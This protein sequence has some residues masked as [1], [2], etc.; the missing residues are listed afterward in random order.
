VP[1]PK[2]EDLRKKAFVLYSGPKGPELVNR[3]IKKFGIKEEKLNDYQLKLVL[4]NIIKNVFV[5]F[6]GLESTKL[7]L[8]QDVTHVP[9][10][11]TV[12]EEDT[13]SIHIFERINFMRTF[14]IFIA[15]LI[16]LVVSIGVYYVVTFNR[17]ELCDNK[18]EVSGRDACFLTLASGHRNITFCDKLSDSQRIY[19]CYSLVGKDLNDTKICDRI[20]T[21]QVDLIVLHNNCLMCIA[22]TLKN[23]SMC[24]SF[25]NQI[26]VDECLTQIERKVSLTC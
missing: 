22:V 11:H 10:Y 2:I 14:T 23:E 4:N 18:K 8:A 5:D 26:Q 9:G 13:E 25:Q 17:V 6:I 12:I 15:V 19:S 20:P 7:A 3:E 21:D 16:V 1:H 24:R